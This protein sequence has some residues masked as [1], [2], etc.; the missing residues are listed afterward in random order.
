MPANCNTPQVAL[1]TLGWDEAWEILAA[2]HRG[3]TPA[4]VTR[5]D[6]GV[7]T[8]LTA[9]GPVRASLGGGV[10]DLAAREPEQ[11][12]CAGDWVMLRTWP[13]ARVTVEAVL[14]RRTR[15]VRA[16]AGARARAQVLAANVGA[17]G[18]TVAL[19]QIPSL[20]KVE[21]LLALAW[22][23]GAV[24]VVLLT[25]ADIARDA[26]DVAADVRSSAPGVGVI[27]VSTGTDLGVPE[28][29]GLVARVGTLALVGSS[30]AGKST[31]V[32]SL[33]GASVLTTR[34]IREDG[35]GRHTTVRRELVV[36]PS[37]GCVI[38]TPGL[39]GVGLF[40]TS[41]GLTQTFADLSALAERCRFRDCNHDSEPGCAVQGAVDAGML[42]LR[43]LESWR[44]LRREQAWMAT[45][46]D[47]RLRAEQGRIWRARSKSARNAA[48][49]P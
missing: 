21:R 7:C 38:D 45:R 24:P 6:R 37:G 44:R 40:D 2:A 25:K 19:D 43:R 22:D 27:C 8:A 35:R 26:A 13:D 46:R 39:R 18:V 42:A 11:A 49:R 15:V 10:L 32:N 31:L 28:L 29:R 1:S 30:G 41:V 4:R 34:P 48:K 14:A 47:A 33:V 17:V 3:D 5:G 36:L 12:P 16:E 20:T 9:D 23:S